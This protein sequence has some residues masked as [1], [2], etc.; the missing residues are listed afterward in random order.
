M[1]V[2]NTSL[3]KKMNMDL[4][5]KV[6]REKRSAT[7]PQLAALTG[8]SVVTMHSLMDLFLEEKEVLLEEASWSVGGRPAARYRYN[9]NYRLAIV[10]YASERSISEKESTDLISLGVINLYGEELEHKELILNESTEQTILDTIGLMIEQ[11]QQVQAIGIGMPGQE[12]GGILVSSDYPQLEGKAFVEHVRERF[13]LPVCYENDVNLAVLGY[14]KKQACEDKNVV[15]IFLPE[16]YPLGIGIFLNGKLYRG[17]DGFAGEAKYLP[18]KIDWENPERVSAHVEEAMEHLIMIV[19]CLFN[20]ELLLIYWKRVQPKQIETAVKAC[21]K[22]INAAILPEVRLESDFQKDFVQ[23]I[24]SMT[25]QLLE[26]TE[27]R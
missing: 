12:V 25:L 7:I 24:I 14:C 10:L 16:K 6:L 11:F 2:G 26:E 13:Q 8:L 1:A 22:K 19:T 23:G 18:D 17:K 20:P 27:S 4:V 21:S 15:G 9:E 5:R 3:L